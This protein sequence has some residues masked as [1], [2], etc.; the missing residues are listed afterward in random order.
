MRGWTLV[1]DLDGTLIDTAPDLAAATNHVLSR[2]GLTPVDEREIRPWVGHGALKMIERATAAHGRVLSEP[3]LYDLFEIFILY[4]A[5]HIAIHSRPYA[6]V[7]SALEVCRAQ[8]ATLAVCTNK[9]ERHARAVLSELNMAKFFAA[10]AGR[11]TLGVFKPDP[12]HLTGTIEQARGEKFRAVM[13]GDSETDIR[14]AKAASTPIVAVSFGY[15][16]EPIGN[17]GPDVIIS[18]YDQLVRAIDGLISQ[19]TS[20]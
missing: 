20:L 5:D 19:T 12:G 2:I 11:D 6:G 13:I 18:H 4:Y 14:T 3:E 1:F 16:T 17:Y 9:L 10:V 7:I 8:G 15:S